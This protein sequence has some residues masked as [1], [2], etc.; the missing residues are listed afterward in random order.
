MTHAWNERY[1]A[2]Y[3]RTL[4]ILCNAGIGETFAYELAK[5]RTLTAALKSHEQ[6]F[7]SFVSE[8]SDLRHLAEQNAS[9]THEDARA[10]ARARSVARENAPNLPVTFCLAGGEGGIRTRSP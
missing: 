9:D 6:A 2:L 10:A 4:Q 8:Q 7:L 5:E 3:D 1:R